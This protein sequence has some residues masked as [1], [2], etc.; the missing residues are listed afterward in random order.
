MT[1]GLVALAVLAYLAYIASRLLA[2]R[3][4]P[5]LVGFLVVGAILG[6][7]GFELLTG[8]DLARLQPA[9]EIALALLMF[10]IGERVSVRA[11]RAARWSVSAGVLQYALAGVGVYLATR[12]AGAEQATALLLGS[13]A[14]AGAP[15]TIAAVATSVKA[16]GKYVQG[17]ISTHALKDALAATTFAAVLPVAVLLED[18]SASATEAIGNFVRLGVGGVALGVAFGWLISRFGYQIETSGELLLFVLVHIL[19]GWAVAD[20]MEISLPL[21]ALVAGAVAS[22]LSPPDFSGRLFRTTRTIEQ[23]LYLLFFGLAGAAIHLEDV[24]EVGLIG[25]VYITVRFAGKIVGGLGGGMVGGLGWSDSLRLGID[26]FPQAGVAVGLSVL[27][28]EVLEGSGQE[29]ATVVLGSV[30]VAELIG[31]LVV[32]RGLARSKRSVDDEVKT[33]AVWLEGEPE[34]VLVASQQPL[35]LPDWVLET[36][37]RWHARI[38]VLTPGTDE[39]EHVTE[40]RAQATAA[41]CELESRRWTPGESFTGTVV[42]LQQETAAGL[43]VLVA[44]RPASFG[45][46][47]RLVLLPHERIARQLGVPVLTFPLDQPGPA[48]VSVDEA[49]PRRSLLDRLLRRNRHPEP[50]P[51]IDGRVPTPAGSLAGDAA[52]PQPVPVGDGGHDTSSPGAA[53]A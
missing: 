31:P 29:A 46:A 37:G 26:S 18:E 5:E 4:V 39:D 22:S 19:I 24:P 34:V 36:S 42:R 15:L 21:G 49:T 40:L 41:E 52:R 51:D 28:S 43:V 30:V 12:A 27:A 50:D 35:P 7:S 10:I 1:D 3:K 44:R 8:D 33:E 45:S 38:V 53:P 2:R 13:L 48:P 32:A 9:T 11:L 25:L 23:P 16:R 6:P 14:G 17:L 20:A 47:S